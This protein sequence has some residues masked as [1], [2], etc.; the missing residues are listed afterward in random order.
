MKR[1]PFLTL[2]F[3]LPALLLC[4]LCVAPLLPSASS[5]SLPAQEEPIRPRIYGIGWVRLRVTNL[6]KAKHFYEEILQLKEFP[7]ECFTPAAVCL[8]I[9]DKQKLELIP[10]SSP[11]DKGGLDLVGFF[12]LDLNK[13]RRYLYSRGLLPGEII[14]NERQYFE[15]PDFRD[16]RVAFESAFENVDF[17]F[18]PVS[19]RLIH[20]GFIVGDR[21]K[22]DKFFRDTLDFSLYWHG[23]RKDDETSWVDMQVPDGT[24]WV[25]YM[26]NISPDADHH[27]LGVMNHI[28][29]GV[30]DIHATQQQLIKNGWAGIEEPKIGRGGKWQLNLYDPDDTRVELMEFTPTQKPCCSEYTGPHPGQH[31]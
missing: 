11:N 10:T 6:E 7:N 20:A 12:T 1:A 21:T 8:W 17:V 3:R 5:P 28:A 23:R 18:S 16:H 27:T 31:P 24:D 15:L 2:S 13:M 4:A 14:H 9:D 25:E 22:E 30:K 29:L 19:S 26:L